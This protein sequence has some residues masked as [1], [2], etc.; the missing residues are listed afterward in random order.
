[1]FGWL[2]ARVAEFRK[3]SMSRAECSSDSRATLS[4]RSRIQ[5]QKSCENG[6]KVLSVG[7]LIVSEHCSR[8]LQVYFYEI[9]KKQQP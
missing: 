3:R 6:R 5:I 9:E 4:V 7:S 2:T 8:T 1:M